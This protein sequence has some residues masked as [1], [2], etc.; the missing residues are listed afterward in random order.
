M[1]QNGG[2]Q[3][4]TMLNTILVN[5]TRTIYEMIALWIYDGR[6]T[7]DPN[8]EFFVVVNPSASNDSLWY[9]KYGIKRSMLPVFIRMDQARKVSR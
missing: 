6:L 3:L 9:D 4:R 2:P 7:A 8:Q 5:V 1:A